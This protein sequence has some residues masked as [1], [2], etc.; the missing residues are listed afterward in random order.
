VLVIGISNVTII[1]LPS[2]D[3]RLFNMYFVIASNTNLFLLF[4]HVQQI[5]TDPS[6]LD[7]IKDF[8]YINI[9]Y[10]NDI[11]NDLYGGNTIQTVLDYSV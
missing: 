5:L 9:V 1:V 7:T 10:G 4:Y 8:F 6:Y 3:S 2:N 11:Y